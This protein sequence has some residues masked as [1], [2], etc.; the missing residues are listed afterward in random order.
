MAECNACLYNPVCE[1]WREAERQD[2]CSH[3]TGGLADCPIYKPA[4]D[5]VEVRHGEWKP[6]KYT[7][8]PLYY[9]SECIGSAYKQHRYCPNCGAKMDGKGEDE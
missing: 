3:L 6:V 9:C 1:L 8:A 2:A 7:E 5:L 4:A